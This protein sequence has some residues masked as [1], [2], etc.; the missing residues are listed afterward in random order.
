MNSVDI[1]TYGSK[2]AEGVGTAAVCRDSV[3]MASL[4]RQASIYLAET[5][6]IHLA[7]KFVEENNKEHSVIYNNSLSVLQSLNTRTDNSMIRK[8]LHDVYGLKRQ[9][10]HI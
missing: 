8:L 10:K 9:N 3:K 7:L 1:Y 5:Y 6:A 4:L 2:S